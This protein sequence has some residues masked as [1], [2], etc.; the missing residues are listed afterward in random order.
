MIPPFNSRLGAGGTGLCLI[1]VRGILSLQRGGGGLAPSITSVLLIGN[2]QYFRG[3]APRR[4]GR[5]LCGDGRCLPAF[6]VKHDSLKVHGRPQF[7]VLLI[8]GE[9]SGTGI[10]F[11]CGRAVRSGGIARSGAQVG[12][13]FLP[14]RLGFKLVVIIFVLDIDD[15]DGVFVDFFGLGLDVVV[16]G[17]HHHTNV[18]VVVVFE[19]LQCNHT[20]TAKRLFG[21][22]FALSVF[23][24]LKK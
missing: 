2:G 18:G 13:L 24:K 12:A 5:P 17:R 14:I 4:S 3:L 16:N 19:A 21:F 22:H 11:A 6:L 23:S 1:P 9:L 7:A 15:G 8:E 20:C 10:G